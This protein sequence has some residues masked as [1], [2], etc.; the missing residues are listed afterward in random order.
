MTRT[1]RRLSTGTTTPASSASSSTG[2]SASAV[3]LTAWITSSAS[4]HLVE[5]EPA[6]AGV[7][8]GDL[9][10]VLDQLLE[11]ADVGHEQVERRLDALGQLVA[12]VVQTS[13]EAASVVSGE[14]SSWLTSEAKRASRSMRS[15]RARAMSLNEV[16]EGPEV[17]VVARL[18]PG[19]EAAPAMAVAAANVGQG[20]EDPAAE[21]TSR[22]RR[23]PAVVTSGGGE[24]GEAERPQGVARA[25]RGR[26]S[27]SRRRPPRERDADGE[28]QARRRSWKRMRR[29]LPVGDPRRAAS[30]G[31]ASWP[32]RRVARDALAV[33]REHRARARPACAASRAGAAVDPPVRRQLADDLGVEDTLR[34]A[35]SSRWSS[36]VL[37]D[38]RVGGRRQE[39]GQQRG[40][41]GRRRA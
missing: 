32:T 22:G 12:P 16:D 36:E 17:G 3:R 25:R 4:C 40:R 5:V 29:G 15:W 14:R 30:A 21:P 26:R 9:E 27:R 7:E 31:R 10:Q 41:R 19:V 8:A 35:A 11:A 6:G 39:D 34:V 1:S 23:R 24:Q 2:T 18:E 20:P 33:R 13:T 38:E 28:L 37:A